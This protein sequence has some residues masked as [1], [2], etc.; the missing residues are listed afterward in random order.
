MVDFAK[1]LNRPLPPA[2][3]VPELIVGITG[4]RP[5]KLDSAGLR[6]QEPGFNGYD[7]MNPLRRHLCD[8][9]RQKVDDIVAA[10]TPDRG[11]AN[12]QLLD[13]YL[14]QVEW[15]PG[16]DWRHLRVLGVSGVALG[17]DQ[18]F[19]GVLARMSPPVPYIAAVP[20]P[21]Q[22]SIWPEP[23]RRVY[24]AVLD[25]AVGVVMVSQTRPRSKDEAGMMLGARN[26]WICG[27][28]DELIAVHDGSNGGTANCV[29]G[30]RRMGRQPHIIDPRDFRDRR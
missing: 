28:V 19:C 25:R 7:R 11:R 8:A 12:K 22:D 20:F 13:S 2:P 17:I 1:W 6:P 5:T 23:S 18:D 26:D 10:T 29:R 3:N 16:V 15:K 24:A 30:Y 9:M 4:H 21:G 27:V 14:R